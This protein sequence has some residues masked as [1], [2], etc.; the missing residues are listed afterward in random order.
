M[1]DGKMDLPV[2]E[3]KLGKLLIIDDV[4]KVSHGRPQHSSFEL[5]VSF[6]TFQIENLII[7]DV[8]LIT[9]LKYL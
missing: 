7:L 6:L 4:V 5:L 9:F 2:F 3:V 8:R 1:L